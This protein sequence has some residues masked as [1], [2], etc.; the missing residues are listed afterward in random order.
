VWRHS[1]DRSAHTEPAPTER[2]A[3]QVRF[4]A[5]D[6]EAVDAANHVSILSYALRRTASPDAATAILAET[7]LTA[8]RRLDEPPT[9]DKARLWSPSDIS[10][11]SD[12]VLA[13]GCRCGRVRL[14]PGALAVDPSGDRV[15]PNSAGKLAGLVGAR[16][17]NWR[18]WWALGP[19]TC[20]TPR[21]A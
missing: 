21:T 14:R 20:F 10:E 6:F 18:P 19:S 13:L 4:E 3:R 5:V 8:R 2:A 7:F 1:P 15:R 17:A 9:G 16:P 12:V 11:M